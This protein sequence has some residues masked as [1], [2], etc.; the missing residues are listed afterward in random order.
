MKVALI[1][2]LVD[3]ARGGAE[4][5]TLEMARQLARLGLDVTVL[6]RCGSGGSETERLRIV[7]LLPH[8]AKNK[9]SST[10]AFLAAVQEFLA[11]QSP[12]IVHAITP[13][14]GAN[15]YQPR[16]GTY[17]ETI[18]R[19]IERGRSPLDRW[20][21]RLSRRLNRR[22]RFLLQVEQD[23]LG[24]A[25]PPLVAAVSEY[26][27]RQ[28][29]L[30]YPDLPA[31]RT[32]V[33]FNGVDCEPLSTAQ[34]A[35][36]RAVIRDEFNLRADA[37]VVLFAAHNFKLK[38]LTELIR[39]AAAQPA[40]RTW[41]AL[42]VGRDSPGAYRRLAGRLGVRERF[43]F[44]G[45]RRDMP[46]L[47]AASDLLAHPTWYDP[48]SRVVLEA[49]GHGLPVVTTR[50]NG[51]ADAIVPGRGGAVIDGPDDIP[52]L[53]AAIDAQLAPKIAAMCLADA[54]TAR[55][56]LSMARHARELATLFE[57]VSGRFQTPEKSGNQ[58]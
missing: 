39:A 48:C 3:V 4:T 33:V 44:A 47:F 10:Q 16:G 13:C 14:P 9:L 15:V 8:L 11:R 35:R 43:V 7:P 58:T 21:K 49:L 29:A 45:P 54:A 26:V 25:T 22:Q 1:Q 46:E 56:R 36:A 5:S 52:G 41:T 12:D 32:V 30:D 18:R 31:E 38:G 6:C 42:I 53:A 37:P 57:R 40:Q 55:E 20:I 50:F 27:R 2:E 24:G 51:A 23:L 34:R 28:V 17:A 19:S